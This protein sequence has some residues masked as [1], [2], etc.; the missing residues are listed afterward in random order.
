MF[1]IGTME[2]LVIILVGVLVLGPEHLPRIMRTI[3]KV[4]SDFRRVSTDFQRTLNMEAHKEEWERQQTAASSKKSTSKKKTAADKPAKK[5]QAPAKNEPVST[6]MAEKAPEKTPEN[7]KLSSPPDTAELARETRAP[8]A[9]ANVTEASR[10]E[11]DV[12]ERE[13]AVT[14]P[15]ASENAAP[16]RSGDAAVPDASRT[17]GANGIHKPTSSPGEGQA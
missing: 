5:K 12:A 6:A 15:D 2:F 3:N 4:M 14:R 7:P 16:N 10:H 17:A 11:A 8:D 13:N 1:G 9:A